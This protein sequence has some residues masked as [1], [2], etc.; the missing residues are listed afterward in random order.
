MG[1]MSRRKG[2]VGEREALKELGGELGVL[3]HRNL[4]QT[5]F[6]GADCTLVKGFAIEIKRKEDLSRGT[7]WGQAVR[8]AEA[9]GGVEPMLLYRRN[10]E[11]W[12]AF[13]HTENGNY[14]EGTMKDA[15]SAI[16]EKWLAM[17]EGQGGPVINEV[18][19]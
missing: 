4:T 15:A 2:I 1:N 10:R 3:L 16:R 17:G 12:R 8:Q 13:I 7:W 11:P 5:R 19:S 9:I 18:D 6:G 14:R